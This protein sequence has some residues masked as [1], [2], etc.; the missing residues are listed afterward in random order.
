MSAYRILITGTRDELT[1]EQIDKVRY[2]IDMEVWSASGTPVTLVHGDCPTGVDALVVADWY[3]VPHR[4]LEAHP[5]NWS[6][7]CD[8]GCYRRPT[9]GRCPAAGPRRNREMVEAGADVCLAFPM[10]ASRGT[11]GCIALAQA[12]GIPTTVVEL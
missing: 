10:G 6:A 7:P 2:A 8:S 5:A 4:T 11:R 12:A 9:E 3:C 1:G